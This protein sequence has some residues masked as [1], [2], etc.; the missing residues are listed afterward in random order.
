MNH[1]PGKQI[2][3]Y[4]QFRDDSQVSSDLLQ[5]IRAFYRRDLDQSGFTRHY[6]DALGSTQ[7]T[8]YDAQLYVAQTFRDDGNIRVINAV[9]REDHEQG[10]FTLHT[11]IGGEE[12]DGMRIAARYF[13]D[14]DLDQAIDQLASL[15]E[16]HDLGMISLDRTLSWPGSNTPLIR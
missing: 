5:A 13:T 4:D 10:G 12:M 6:I 3:R 11:R 2:E 7:L 14:Q 8:D 15:K 9:L 16:L 1:Q